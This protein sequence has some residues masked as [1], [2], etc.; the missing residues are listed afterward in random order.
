MFPRHAHLSLSRTVI[1]TGDYCSRGDI[2]TMDALTLGL[3]PSGLMKPDFTHDVTTFRTEIAGLRAIAVAIVILF[4]LKVE[5]FGGG[6]VG[7]DIFFVLSGYLITRIIL[8]DAAAGTF[9]LARFYARRIRRIFPALI[10][11]VVATYVVGALWCSPLMF[12]DVAKEGTHALLSI[13]N[14]QY[15]R[16]SH[17]Y[18]A[19]SSDELALLHVWSLSLEEQFYLVWPILIVIAQKFKRAPQFIIFATLSSLAGSIL[20]ARTDASAAFFLTPFRIYEFGCGALLLFVERFSVSR[21]S[22]EVLSGAGVLAI[23]VSSILFR[24]NMPHLEIAMLVPCL[25]ASAVIFAGGGTAAAKAIANPFFIAIGTISYSLYLCHWPIIF[26]ARFIFGEEANGAAATVLMVLTMAVV[27]SAMY[28]YVERPFIQSSAYKSANFART[29]LQFWSVILVLVAVTHATFESR[30]FAWRVP[31]HQQGLARLQDFPTG[32]DM[33]PL[34]GPVAVSLVGDSHAVQYEVGLSA[35]LNRS[36]VN[37]EILGG[38]GCPILH[39]ATLKA[40]QRRQDCIVARDKALA[41]VRGATVP[42]I[43]NQF[44]SYYDDA[45]ID[46]DLGGSNDLRPQSKGSYSKLEVALSGT[47]EQFVA[48]G[49]RV[50]LIGSQVDASCSF[51][52]SRLYQGPLP[53]AP[54][55]P[56]PPGK[57]DD[58]ERSGAKMNEMLARI[59]SKW[60]SSV[61]LLRPVDYLCDDECPTMKDG[62]WLYFDGTHFSVAGSHHMVERAETPLRQFLDF[63]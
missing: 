42:I 33:A 5:S 58:A 39:G 59:A 57:R 30:G 23:V 14:I 6:F 31:A 10:V 2:T 47:L 19:P 21:I 49:R 7:V 43:F 4:H 32:R 12:L 3:R 29:A 28:R 54:L 27:A 60:P 37:M 24:S 17:K 13:S 25:G 50:L 15:W 16:E 51:N 9:S 46:Y 26:F 55:Q 48:G 18:F 62:L 41:H 20:V 45:T 35:L 8:R 40:H 36:G 44:W 1:K 22:R 63:R 34:T 53:H 52:R 56:C 38:A 11:T 61:T